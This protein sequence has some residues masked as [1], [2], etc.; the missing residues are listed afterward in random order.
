MRVRGSLKNGSVLALAL[1]ACLLPGGRAAAQGDG[2]HNLPLAP[3]GMN[4]FVTTGLYLTGNFN[5]QQTVLIPQANVDGFAL[6]L[7]YVHTFGLGKQFARVFATVPLSTLEANAEVPSRKRNVRS[8]PE[9]P[10]AGQ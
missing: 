10:V 9:G 7:T 5:P 8:T 4:L 1:G 3:T 2:P 6:P